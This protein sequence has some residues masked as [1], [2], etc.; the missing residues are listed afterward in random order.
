MLKEYIDLSY[1]PRRSDLICMFKIKPNRISM[2][3]AAAHVAAESAVGTWR[4]VGGMNDRMKKMRARVFDIDGNYVKIAY[5]EVLFEKDNMA[6]VMS[7]IAGNIFGMKVVNELRLEDIDFPD[8]FMRIYK[9]PEFGIRGIRSHMKIK[10]RPF[11]GAIIKPKIGLKTKQHATLAYET[12]M[13]G[14]DIIKD[15]ENLSNQ[16]FNPFKDRVVETYAVKDKASSETGE[17]KEYMPNITAETETMLERMDF[18][19]SQGG[20]YAMVDVVTTGFSTIQTIRKNSKG[21]ILH[22]H[23][24][25]HGAITRGNQGISMLALAK[26]YRLIG[27]DQLHIGT[28]VG[29]MEGDKTEVVNIWENIEKKI[30]KK[31]KKEHILAE[32]WGN[33]K[34]V[35]AVCSGGLHPSHI[36]ALVKSFGKDI[37]IQAG[38]GV[39]GHP[40]GS[41][42]G[43]KAMR[44]S[45]DA[46][47]KNISLKRYSKKYNELKR[48]LDHW[49]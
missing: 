5:P 9:G 35:F 44:Q 40:D 30:V 43:A 26:I 47:M 21:I 1:K 45:V 42:A 18:I 29:K 38:G 10:E 49:K 34:P 8:D 36:P 19:R 23:R 32:N 6:Q 4:E 41:R 39:H 24:A 7:S 27:V 20:K 14:I 28:I 33:I 16:R 3:K 17:V 25:M 15:D 22:A 12:W 2:K 13:G 31:D 37:I 46:V 48:A 11:V